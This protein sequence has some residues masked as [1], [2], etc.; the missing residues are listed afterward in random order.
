MKQEY[1][2]RQKTNPGALLN[3]D[4]EGKKAYQLKR[5]SMKKNTDRLNDLENKVNDIDDTLKKI[6]SILEKDK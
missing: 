4:N 1:I 3:T 6:L 5:A 2:V